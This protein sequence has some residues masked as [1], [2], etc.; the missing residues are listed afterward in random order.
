MRQ[1]VVRVTK[2]SG[3]VE[4]PLKAHSIVDARTEAC[5]RFPGALTVETV[6]RK[7]KAGT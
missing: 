2:R 4:V 1:F 6:G 3:T 7:P 5:E